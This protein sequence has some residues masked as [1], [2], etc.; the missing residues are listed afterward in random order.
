[1]P[2][3]GQKTDDFFV[4]P[5]PDSVSAA[6]LITDLCKERLP[7]KMGIAAN[8]IQVLSPTRKGIAGTKDLNEKLQNA[9]N[10]AAKN[11]NETTFGTTTYR[12]GDRVMQIRNNYELLWN[13]GDEVG[14]GVFN[15]DVGSVIE[16]DTKTQTL[17]VDYEDRT[18]TYGFDM[19]GELEP[20]FAMT[21]H[22]SQGSE[23]RAVILSL[24]NV[25]RLLLTKSI[26]Y[27]AVTRARELLIIVGNPN[28]MAAMVA[29]DKPRKR[30]SGL[31]ARLAGEATGSETAV[32]D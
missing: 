21:V 3:Q 31:R 15:G 25:P 10:P 32:P 18:A 9:L 23:Y 4:M 27:T 7:G 29:N 2:E 14:Q 20:A 28:E 6:E 12:E 24:M 17:T 30:Y 8:Q 5:R 26:L 19:L 11:K 22:K 13:K 1:M 16:I